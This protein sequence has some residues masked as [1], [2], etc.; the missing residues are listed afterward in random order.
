MLQ[1]KALKI[2]NMY[3]ISVR[4]FGFLEQKMLKVLSPLCV[5]L[6]LASCGGDSG[7]ST[8]TIQTSLVQNI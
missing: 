8:P 5:A 1:I 6:L 2:T 4:K 3:Y 7:E